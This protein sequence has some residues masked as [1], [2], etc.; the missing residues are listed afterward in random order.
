MNKAS[1][2]N[3]KRNYWLFAGIFLLVAAGSYLWLNKSSN[4]SGTPY[5]TA[6]ANLG[7]LASNVE[8][9]GTLR[10]ARSAT[11]V[12]NTSGRVEAVH[13]SVGDKVSTDQVLASLARD[14]ASSNVILAEADLVTAQQNLDTLLQS[15]SDVAQA[16]QN[17]A[18]AKQSVSDAQD[19]LAFYEWTS[20]GRGPGALM[21]ELQDQMQPLHARL[22]IIE[23]VGNKF[24][25]NTPDDLRRKADFNLNLLTT[26]QNIT[27]LITRYNWFTGRPSD[28]LMEQT[29]AAVNL[30]M[31]R[32][33]DAQREL[34][35][36]NNGKNV[37]DLVA[38]RAKLAAAQA[39]YNLSKI[40]APFDG[41]VTQSVPQ[42]G[43]KI[44]TGQTAFRVDDLSHLMVDLQISEVDINNVTIGQLVSIRLDAVPNKTY[45]GLVS[46]VDQSASAGQT[47]VNF[48]V[49]V[50]LTDVDEQIKPG[51]TAVVTITTKEVGNALLV[52]NLA[53]RMVAGQRIVYI[54]KNNQAV[55]V[56]VR[57]G[58]NANDNSQV[59]GGDLKAGDLIILNPPSLGNAATQS[60]SPA[61]TP[62]K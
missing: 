26:K 47:G 14:T 2:K 20:L 23:W 19:T 39:T 36:F 21:T 53:V 33:E 4:G 50:T 27:D 55:P 10:A 35:R 48:K 51:M 54:L 9:T 15:N 62:T 18:D 6:A 56:N 25:K 30:A 44:S 49:S 24:Y 59:V 38:A 57:L 29:R 37:D 16:M 7:S 28:I 45:K 31:A 42:P 11:L 43:D 40:M 52:P 5:Q 32:Q 46:R 17:L 1:P 13:A 8:A 34:D 22:K 12:W 60:A 61:N 3:I 58:A 41:T